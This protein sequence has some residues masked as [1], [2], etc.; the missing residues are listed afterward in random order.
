M[1]EPENSNMNKN[2]LKYL[3]LSG[4]SPSEIR[5]LIK[6][7]FWLPIIFASWCQEE[8]EETGNIEFFKVSKIFLDFR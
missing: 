4:L 1:I 7:K 8:Y 5:K 6:S 2:T 3:I